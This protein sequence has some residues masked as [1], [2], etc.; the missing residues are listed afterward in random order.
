MKY[1][2]VIIL[3][4]FVAGCYIPQPR[5]HSRACSHTRGEIS[6]KD[7]S[8]IIP[9][10]TF[11]EELLLN[12][13]EPDYISDNGKILVYTWDLFNATTF[14]GHASSPANRDHHCFIVYLN[15]KD[16]IIETK[17]FEH[18]YQ[19]NHY[20]VIRQELEKGTITR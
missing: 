12:V 15:D 17:R 18:S 11:L 14:I 10:Q 20:P 5:Y 19:G 4:L 3:A 2:L 16:I 8:F 13:G 9:G 6:K 1:K 7:T